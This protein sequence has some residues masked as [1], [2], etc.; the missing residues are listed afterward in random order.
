[1]AC[2]KPVVNGRFLAL[3]LG[4][5]TWEVSTLFVFGRRGA[6]GCKRET[7]WAYS[8]NCSAYGSQQEIR[9]NKLF[10]AHFL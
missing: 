2:E 4:G 9:E 6:I 1:M 8:T 5:Y 10:L 7:K 3:A